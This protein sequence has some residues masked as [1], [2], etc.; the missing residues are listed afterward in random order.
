MG[1]NTR[2]HR[3]VS[4]ATRERPGREPVSIFS[5][6]WPSV[7]CSELGFGRCATSLKDCLKYMDVSI[8]NNVWLSRA[9]CFPCWNGWTSLRGIP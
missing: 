7:T 6:A 1:T 4:R 2:P 8:P 9:Q 5:A 3:L